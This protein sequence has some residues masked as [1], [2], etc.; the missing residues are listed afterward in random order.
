MAIRDEYQKHSARGYYQKL[1]RS[2]RNP[3]E[4]VVAELLALLK[5]EPCKTLDLA[6]G[7]G[8]ATLALQKLGFDDITGVDP[9]TA[10][11]YRERTGRTALAL[12]FEEIQ[13]G[14]LEGKRFGL[15]VCSFALHLLAPSRLPALLW[16]LRDAAP[17]L[18]ILTPHKRP[19]IKPDT[20]WRL[21]REILH[22]RVRAREYGSA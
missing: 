8:E 6:C 21:V 15:I 22:K 11:A 16:R 17:R 10:E 5:L 9:F 3:H 4:P 1:G 18:L 13:A 20:G 2:Y 19:K 14:G 12:T 7:S